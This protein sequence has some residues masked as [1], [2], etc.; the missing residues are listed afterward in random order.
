MS[1]TLLG[2]GVAIASVAAGVL[3]GGWVM[4]FKVLAPNFGKLNPIS[5][6]GNLFSKQQLIDALKSCL[7]ALT[8]AITSSTDI[9]SPLAARS[10]TSAQSS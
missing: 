9:R 3:S 7:L 6:I 8:I 10:G 4:S 1:E 2:L 5:G